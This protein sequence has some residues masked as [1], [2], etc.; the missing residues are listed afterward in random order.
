MKEFLNKGNNKMTLN[1]YKKTRKKNLTEKL[2]LNMYDDCWVE[3]CDGEPTFC[4]NT[5][6][7]CHNGIISSKQGDWYY[8]NGEVHDY[9]IKRWENGKLYDVDE[10][11]NEVIYENLKEEHIN[12]GID[13]ESTGKSRM[14]L[15]KAIGAVQKFNEDAKAYP[16]WVIKSSKWYDPEGL[17]IQNKDYNIEYAGTEQECKDK[18]SQIID[19]ANN[20]KYGD[21]VIEDYSDTFVKIYYPHAISK[22]VFSVIK[23]PHM[24]ESLKENFYWDEEDSFFTR[25]DLDE[26][27]AELEYELP[28]VVFHKTYFEPGNFLEVDWD[29]EGWEE[30]TKVKVD[31]RRIHYPRDLIRRYAPIVIGMIKDSYEKMERELNESY[32]KEDWNSLRDLAEEMI[33]YLNDN[34][35]S[36]VDIYNINDDGPLSSITLEIDGDW[37][38]DHLRANYL[39]NMK[40]GDKIKSIQDYS[41]EDTGSDW[42][43]EAHVIRL[44]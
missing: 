36:W 32:L 43:K 38:H 24:N 16:Y 34:D 31:M 4:Y 44:K 12:E 33:D 37:K 6:R 3:C 20:N 40:Y 29:Y 35:I 8:G 15:Y 13:V 26:F 42:G 7:D 17:D 2:D 11:T 30:T 9:T 14:P 28:E 41:L 18:I 1:E 23:N 27:Q 21:M 25:D 19:K 10:K 5:L 39:L 22:A